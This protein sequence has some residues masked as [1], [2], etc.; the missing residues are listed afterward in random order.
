MKLTQ[1]SLFEVSIINAAVDKGYGK[2]IF[3]Y[4]SYACEFIRGSLITFTIEE[5]PKLPSDWARLKDRVA[6]DLI[7][8]LQEVDIKV[9]QWDGVNWRKLH[10]RCNWIGNFAGHQIAWQQ[11]QDLPAMTTR[12]KDAV[13]DYNAAVLELRLAAREQSQLYVKAREIHLAKE[14]KLPA[15]PKP[16][17]KGINPWFLGKAIYLTQVHEYGDKE[18]RTSRVMS[19][20][21]QLKPDGSLDCYRIE[22]KNSVYLCTMIKVADNKLTVEERIE[23]FEE[24]IKNLKVKFKTVT[25]PVI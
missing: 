11:T 18:I 19:V 12:L 25:V 9:R 3:S 15:K 2:L 4:E 1:L 13:A 21:K 6:V 24:S 14:A 10:S 23:F 8:F 16:I 20:T 17:K 7:P 22:T 5:V